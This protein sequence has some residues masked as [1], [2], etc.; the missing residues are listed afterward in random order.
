MNKAVVT[1][2]YYAERTVEATYGAC[3]FYTATNMLY[4][5]KGYFAPIMR[6]RLLPCWMAAT[7]LNATVVFMLLKP[8][9]KDEI[10]K[11]VKK[12]IAMGKWLYSMYHL[13]EDAIPATQ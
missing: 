7:A 8:L 3:A 13:E 5:K 2:L 12:R 10:S 9:R 11:Q 6:T 4:I 1:R